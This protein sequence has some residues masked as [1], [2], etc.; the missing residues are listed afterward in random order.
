MR[1]LKRVNGR[2]SLKEI[3]FERRNYAC[4]F[5]DTVS[6]RCQIYQVRPI[7]CQ[8]YPFW[9]IF[10]IKEREGPK[11]SVP[12]SIIIITYFIITRF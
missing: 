12:G 10:K 7:Q 3:E 5:F 2:Y 1:Y 9:E 8:R 4:I 11:K 6:R